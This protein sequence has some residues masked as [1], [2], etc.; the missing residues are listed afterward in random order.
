ME[1][2]FRLEDRTGLRFLALT[3]P[4]PRH[5]HHHTLAQYLEK[6]V[7][8]GRL[9]LTHL[10]RLHPARIREMKLHFVVDAPGQPALAPG[11]RLVRAVC[12]SFIGKRLPVWMAGWPTTSGHRPRWP[13]LYF[14]LMNLT[15][16]SCFRQ[17]VTGSQP[18]RQ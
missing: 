10:A 4:V 3:A 18:A 1:V 15:V 17:G 8:S 16:L 11:D 5:V 6:K 2:A 9:S 14:R 13:S 7:E 12:D